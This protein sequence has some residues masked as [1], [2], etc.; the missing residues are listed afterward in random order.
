MPLGDVDLAGDA[1]ID[2][3]EPVPSAAQMAPNLNPFGLS[4]QELKFAE[5]YAV[6]E[7]GQRAADFAGYGGGSSTASKLLQDDRIRAEIA[8]QR[9]RSYRYKPQ[10]AADKT[11]GEVLELIQDIAFASPLDLLVQDPDTGKVRFKRLK[12]IPQDVRNAIKSVTVGKDGSVNIQLLDRWAAIQ[13][14]AG[15]HGVGTKML[16]GDGRTVA[17]DL[18]PEGEEP[19]PEPT[20][21]LPVTLEN[22]VKLNA[23]RIRRGVLDGKSS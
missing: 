10:G 16:P 14:L 20:K 19:A 12:D 18:P 8:R 11:A 1:P 6:W 3:M 22:V 5:A 7:N 21:Q 23:D 17:E 9:N 15:F 13:R 2:V 4:E